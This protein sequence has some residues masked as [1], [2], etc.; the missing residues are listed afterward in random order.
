MSVVS[1]LLIDHGDL[2]SLAAMALESRSQEVAV[3][4]VRSGAAAAGCCEAAA[5]ERAAAYGAVGFEVIDRPVIDGG[6]GGGDGSGRLEGLAQACLL[7]HAA[8]HA[9]R[10]ACT[11][12]V[13]P[14]QIGPDPA[15]VGEAVE[16]A[17]MVCELAGLGSGHGGRGELA[18]PADFAGLTID[19]PVVDL[20]DKQCAD[21]AE[22]CGAPLACFWPCSQAGAEPCHQ[23]PGCRRWRTA[24]DEAG[25][26]WPWQAVAV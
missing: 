8:A 10:L 4:H 23:C 21:L 24:F 26:G 12:I 11:R 17:A 14:L 20:T 6:G 19:L 2:P 22:D 13:W 5:R 1:A 9:G 16:R 3:L 7:L 25:V 15:L 18:N